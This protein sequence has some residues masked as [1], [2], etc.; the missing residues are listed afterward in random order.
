MS[1]TLNGLPLSQFASKKIPP[2][3]RRRRCCCQRVNAKDCIS[4]SASTEVNAYD[5]APNGKDW[6]VFSTSPLEYAHQSSMT[7]I[8]KSVLWSLEYLHI[9]QSRTFKDSQSQGAK[10]NP[11]KWVWCPAFGVCRAPKARSAGSSCSW[12]KAT[13]SLQCTFGWV[14]VFFQVKLRSIACLVSL[15]QATA[16]DVRVLSECHT[17]LTLREHLLISA[18]GSKSANLCHYLTIS[19][20]VPAI[21]CPLF[22]RWQTIY[23]AHNKSIHPDVM[24]GE[25]SNPKALSQCKIYAEDY[26]TL[27]V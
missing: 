13:W 12:Q 18:S 4:P 14:V 15:G 21:F 22:S 7:T 17:R 8:L 16:L 11:Y 1:L 20:S 19:K 10:E 24:P 9:L 23:T 26:K 2:I 5:R 3:S 25:V 6:S 27:R